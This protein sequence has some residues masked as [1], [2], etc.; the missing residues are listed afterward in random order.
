MDE[1]NAL[2]GIAVGV[3]FLGASLG[4]VGAAVGMLAA[5]GAAPAAPDAR[6]DYEYEARKRLYHAAGPTM[7]Q[8]SECAET[9]LARIRA[10]A[11][12]ATAG[13]LS[14]DGKGALAGDGP[15]L[16]ACL[17]E[18]TAPLAA[19]RLMARRLSA[20]DVSV[21]PWYGDL[22]RSLRALEGS[23]GADA[24]L[25]AVAPRLGYEPD[26]PNA[27]FLQNSEPRTYRRQGL[28]PQFQDDVVESLLTP[29]AA[30]PQRLL[31]AGEFEAAYGEDGGRV[32]QAMR[33]LAHL[34]TGFHPEA[35]PVLWRI[36]VLQIHLLHTFAR[37]GG[38]RGE[39]FVVE[40]FPNAERRRYTVRG[41]DADSAFTAVHAYLKQRLGDGYGKA[42]PQ[43]EEAPERPAKRAR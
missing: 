26:H 38:E 19:A 24:D 23:L 18:L 21:D 34:L 27:R 5:R 12:A 43:A 3:G 6:A 25:A 42:R 41:G 33:G 8:L 32:R 20:L 4:M 11:A 17:Y 2:M 31:T 39:R 36:L 28:P 1:A 35:R 13:E 29:A 22:L 7:T 9:S 15:L 37:L 40:T 14:A 10:L 16:R 30:G